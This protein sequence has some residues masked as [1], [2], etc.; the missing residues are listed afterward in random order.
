M[1]QCFEM[2]CTIL[3]SVH[4]TVYSILY[5]GFRLW[6]AVK[7]RKRLSCSTKL[8]KIASWIFFMFYL[9]PKNIATFFSR[10]RS[11]R[12]LHFF[13]LNLGQCTLA[14]LERK[15]IPIPN[16]FSKT[17][18]LHTVPKIIWVCHGWTRCMD[19]RCTIQRKSAIVRII[20]LPKT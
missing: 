18:I 17:D 16:T 19:S 20:N 3:Y 8:I 11:F 10:F 4:C 5:K 15:R 6:T 14:N 9:G 2:F 13:S 7:V 12:Q 1:Y